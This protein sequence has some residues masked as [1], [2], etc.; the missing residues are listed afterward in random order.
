MYDCECVVHVCGCGGWV[1]GWSA[2]LLCGVSFCSVSFISWCSTPRQTQAKSMCSV[3]A[4][5]AVLVATMSE[6]QG[7]RL[8]RQLCRTTTASWRSLSEWAVAALF[9]FVCVVAC[10]G[11]GACWWRFQSVANGSR[12][13]VKQR[14]FFLANTHTDTLSRCALCVRCRQSCEE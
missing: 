2:T 12:V 4:P 7:Q 11:S 3:L 8:W 10:Y 14:L 13:A 1:N 9:D 6:M 5:S